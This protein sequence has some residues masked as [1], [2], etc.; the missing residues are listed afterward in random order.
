[1]DPDPDSSSSG[2]GEPPDPA[3]QAAADVERLMSDARGLQ[4]IVDLAGEV[5]RSRRRD[6]RSGPE[7]RTPDGVLTTSPGPYRRRPDGGTPDV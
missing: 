2:R 7:A 3:L 4:R 5:A 1:M 6:R